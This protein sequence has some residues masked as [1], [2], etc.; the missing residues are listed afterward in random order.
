MFGKAV[1]LNAEALEELVWNKG[2]TCAF[3]YALNE[4]SIMYSVN[5]TFEDSSGIT[6]QFQ[7]TLLRNTCKDILMIFT[8]MSSNC[9]VKTSK[10]L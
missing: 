9:K 6:I 3:N 2:S 5:G 4:R 1:V 10:V 7:W 8:V